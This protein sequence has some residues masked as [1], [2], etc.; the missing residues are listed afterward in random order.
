MRKKLLIYLQDVGGTRYLLPLLRTVLKDLPDVETLY[1][2]HPLSEGIVRSRSFDPT[3]VRTISGHLAD[4]ECMNILKKER[5]THLLCTLSSP[6]F[7]PTNCHLIQAARRAK[8]PTLGF[9]D[10]WKG[11]D[12]FYDKGGDPSFFTDWI[13]CP[14]QFVR[15]ELLKRGISKD[16][17]HIIGHPG[18]EFLLNHR[19]TRREN[20]E[21]K[22]IL[23]VSQPLLHDR[24]FRGIFFRQDGSKPLLER[25]IETFSSPQWQL[26]YRPHPKEKLA[27]LPKGIIKAPPA[28][29]EEALVEYDLFLGLNSMMLFEA[30]LVGLPCLLLEVPELD[31]LHDSPI[32]YH[33]GK[34]IRDFK[35]LTQ[36]CNGLLSGD[37]LNGTGIT[38]IHKLDIEVFRQQLQGSLDR[39]K[40]LLRQLMD[41][42]IALLQ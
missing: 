22:K 17:L 26:F 5:I 11:Y 4:G 13:G 32:P 36:A 42:P 8:M 25:L 39:S 30:S 31:D 40:Q 34:I 27:E 28:T 7:D 20:H 3:H 35:Q 2:L 12:R 16:R 38:D 23:V 21:G 10:H 1:L 33:Y 14:D 18:L 19:E 29:T 15:D 41:Q 37:P 9:M 24:S 6:Y